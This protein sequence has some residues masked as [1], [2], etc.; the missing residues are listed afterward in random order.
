MTELTDRERA[1]L[2][3]ESA[4]WQLRGAKED[5]IRAQFDVSPIRYTQLLNQ[6]LDR[7]EA[8]AYSPT[9]VNRLRRITRKAP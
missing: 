8:L 4:W 1:I 2:D 7:P 9:V 5:A 3:F 6:L